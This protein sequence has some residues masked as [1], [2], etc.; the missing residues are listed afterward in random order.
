MEW[1]RIRGSSDWLFWK[2]IAFSPKPEKMK[3]NESPSKEV[4][5]CHWYNLECIKYFKRCM[6]KPINSFKCIYKADIL[7][8]DN[9]W[10]SWA[11]KVVA[12]TE[13]MLKSRDKPVQVLSSSRI[14]CPQSLVGVCFKAHSRCVASKVCSTRNWNLWWICL[15]DQK[16][17]K[18]CFIRTCNAGI[19]AVRKLLKN[20]IVIN[21]KKT[22]R[23]I[24]T[25][26]E[27][28]RYLCFYISQVSVLI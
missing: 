12:Y 7:T 26:E 28:L 27:N 25:T 21:N 17:Q 11:C 23:Q 4:D 15:E 3:Q 24:Q 19:H 16:E 10:T 14:L 5:W 18:I 2:G 20:I 1:I 13:E 22:Q 8:E 9:A 6:M